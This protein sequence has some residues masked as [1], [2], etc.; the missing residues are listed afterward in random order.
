MSQREFRIQNHDEKS[1][2]SNMMFLVITAY[3]DMVFIHEIPIKYYHLILLLKCSKKR[4]LLV[5]VVRYDIFLGTI[6][7]IFVLNSCIKREK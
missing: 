1:P 7:E 5:N 4:S 3:L 2:C 6:R